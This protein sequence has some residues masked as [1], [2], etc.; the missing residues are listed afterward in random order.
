MKECH[1]L[2]RLYV[3]HQLSGAGPVGDKRRGEGQG[4]NGKGTKRITLPPYYR[5]SK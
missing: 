4:Y 2:F 1:I 3:Q 5:A